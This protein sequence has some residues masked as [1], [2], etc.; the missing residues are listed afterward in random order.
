MS[1]TNQVKSSASG[2]ESVGAAVQ[3][4]TVFA[5]SDGLISES[6]EA[7]SKAREEALAELEGQWEQAPDS[8]DE[9]E[10]DQGDK[11]ALVKGAR[12]SIANTTNTG[13]PSP[14][15]SAPSSEDD[16]EG[17]SGDSENIGASGNPSG[18]ETIA[19]EDAEEEAD[20]EETEEESASDTDK[21]ATESSRTFQPVNS[22]STTYPLN[23]QPEAV[24]D[25]VTASESG[26]LLF[27]LLAN[28][29]DVDVNDSVQNFSL[30]SVTI[31]D[32][33][34][35]VVSGQ[36][37]VEVVDNQLLFDPGNDFQSLAT[38]QEQVV[39]VRYV[40]SDDEGAQSVSTVSITITGTNDAPVAMVD[41]GNV[42]ENGSLFLDVLANDT[43]VDVNDDASIFSLD[44]V[45]VVDG[46]NDPVAGQGSASISGNQLLFNAGTDFDGLA[47]G[48]TESVT[49]QYVMSDDEGAQSTS[50]V[51]ITVNGE[52]DTPFAVADTGEGGENQTLLIDVLANDTDV[53]HDDVP[54]NFTL[55]GVSVVD[56]NG[57]PVVG[58]GTVT[59]SNNQLQFTPGTDFDDLALGEIETVTIRYVMNDNEGAV[60]ES[61]VTLTITGTN[62][63]PVSGDT[64]LLGS[65]SED[66]LIEITEA[67]LLANASDVDG[68]QLSV[69]NLTSEQG[70]IVDNGNGTWSFTPNTHF[71]GT[72][73]FSFDVSDGMTSSAAEASITLT[74]VADTP[75]L[76]ITPTHNDLTIADHHFDSGSEGWTQMWVGTGL[77]AT[78]NMLGRFEGSS[79]NQRTSNT[80]DVP[81][82]VDEL[83]LNFTFYE[84][85]SWD[86]EEF[87]VFVDGQLYHSRSYQIYNNAGDVAGTE[88]LT[89]SQ[90]DIIG[91][92][93]HD[94]SF[95]AV[96]STNWV[97]QAHHYTLKIPVD[98]NAGQVTIGFGSTLDEAKNNESWGI[99]DFNLSISG[100]TSDAIG[101]E[102]T[103]ISLDVASALV[104]TDGSE[105]LTVTFSGIPAGAVLSAGQQ[106]QDGTWSLTATELD[107]LTITPPPHFNGEMTFSV[108]AVSVEATTGE[109]ASTTDTISVNVIS[110]N[111]LPLASNSLTVGSENTDYHFT[112]NDFPFSD[113]AD[114]EDAIDAIQVTQLPEHGQILLDSNGDGSFDTV[115]ALNASV[116]RSDIESGRMILRPEAEFSGQMTVEF[117]VSDGEG[118]SDNAGS[119][120]VITK[121]GD[122]AIAQ[123]DSD[124]EHILVGESGA[125]TGTTTPESSLSVA[126]VNGLSVS[127]AG[128]TSIQG[129]YGV[130][131][132]HPSGDWSYT[133]DGIS[134]AALAVTSSQ[135]Q[136][137]LVAHWRFDQAS[138]GAV[139]DSATT[140][141]GQETATLTAGAMLEANGFNGSAVRLDG[142]DD[143]VLVGDS[144]DINVNSSILDE[145]TLSLAFQFDA[146]NNLTGRQILYEE[147]AGSNGIVIYLENQTLYAGAYN[148]STG[149][150]GDYATQDISSLSAD[151]WH[152][153]ALVLDGTNQQM[154]AFL[155]GQAFAG[156]SVYGE[157]LSGH[158]GDISIGGPSQDGGSPSTNIFH[159]GTHTGGYFQGS[160]DDVRVY[161]RTLSDVEVE[162]VRYDF[163]GLVD[164]FD[165]TVTNGSST[166]SSSLDISLS[167][168]PQAVD[169][170]LNISEDSG[171]TSGQLQSY[172]ADGG[173]V[174][175]YQLFSGPDKGF[176]TVDSDGQYTFVTGSDFEPLNDGESEQVSFTYSVADLQGNQDLGTVLVNVTGQNEPI[177]PLGENLVS[178][179]SADTGDFSGWTITANGGSGWGISGASQEG[180]NSFI[181]SYDWGRKYQLIDLEAKGFSADFLDTAPEVSASEW[182][183]GIS[184]A[185]DQY[186]FK[187][188]LRGAGQEVIDSYD[189][190]ILTASSQWQ[191]VSHQFSGYGTGVRYIYVEHGGKDTEY[192]SGNYGTAIDNTQ[193]VVSGPEPGPGSLTI[194]SSLFQIVDGNAL[195]T[196]LTGQIVENNGFT[197]L[198]QWLLEHEGGA[199]SVS[200]N[201]ADGNN[202]S[203]GVRL[204]HSDANGSVGVEI[205]QFSGL[206]SANGQATQILTFDDLP[207]GHYQLVLGNDG[208]DESSASSALDYPGTVSGEHAYEVAISGQVSVAALPRDPGQ[209]ALI[210][211]ETFGQTEGILT[212]A[213]VNNEAEMVDTGN[214]L[215]YEVFN[216]DVR[217]GQ[218]EFD[219]SSGVTPQNISITI[220][221][222]PL[223][224]LT[225]DEVQVV[226]HEMNASG[227]VVSS[228]TFGFDQASIPEGD[229]VAPQGG[230]GL[231]GLEL[232]E[233]GLD[234]FELGFSEL[235][236][237]MQGS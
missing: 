136:D 194:D 96:V 83:T 145:R 38:G 140:G 59:V 93:V 234:Y 121:S 15:V 109:T 113:A 177:L 166:A 207:S 102:D 163:D 156:G 180:T 92:V 46:N 40:M 220:N 191:E 184:N 65:S 107:S 31:V 176:V 80:Y 14:E 229:P 74:A 141:V 209:H 47:S 1:D 23:Y 233:L 192:W 230:D 117:K 146:E 222:E 3:A 164:H 33:N 226:F 50:T 64:V 150:S 139:A 98:P 48:D 104:D 36:G 111:D 189:T 208:F 174:L 158:S 56:V 129:Q 11:T 89:N 201:T 133:P 57:N 185:S 151:Q 211:G 171:Y 61:E 10:G 198:D 231:Q 173:D 143:Q 112:I 165:Y 44:S 51:E 155:D 221:N 70:S 214:T 54:A 106:H 217:V 37:S 119:L 71:S 77:F 237:D 172:D 193:I 81:Q 29:N 87:R 85:D 90:G 94:E 101:L 235:M 5:A 219:F 2:S 175:T 168:A 75:S 28:D 55:S 199:L 63:A 12:P 78:G 73:D 41:T 142:I 24:P 135:L 4:A 137:S 149:W 124:A 60:S 153:V 132:V 159:D 45:Q 122:A 82:G 49:V 120:T 179:P 99:D 39:T 125:L 115:V 236:D 9:E 123:L 169:E 210:S 187:V 34:G 212:L 190:G 225:L 103:A 16:S 72:A 25:E 152:H 130:L 53:D 181:T 68:G 79:G 13:S 86:G 224:T 84:I 167:R 116:S 134:E 110:V 17:S 200:I 170:T 154:T 32:N 105:S 8:E 148:Q 213:V 203:A 67:A 205:G 196:D 62:D 52:N 30:D 206:M 20:S 35:D 215:Y 232:I 27:D 183:L 128:T 216:N 19:A 43:D 218:G 195:G 26:A 127:G 21:S 138:N 182:F 108:T 7:E 188:E 197:S 95:Q 157:G 126:S 204:L 18:S 69:Q 161:N 88:T 160:I 42:A 6:H 186:Y 97:D 76:S 114:P 223:E 144:T 58:Q 22:Q 202:W 228:Q 91:Q 227:E 118:W 131:Q 162:A 100:S 178:N 66:S 147:G